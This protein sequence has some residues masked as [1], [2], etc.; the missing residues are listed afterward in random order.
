M[1]LGFKDYAALVTLL[2][3]N[4][5]VLFW[6]VRAS[7]NG[8]REGQKSMAGDVREIK[9][10]VKEIRKSDADQNVRLGRHEERID[11]LWGERT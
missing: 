8:M 9:G 10:D 6:A 2:A 7:L 4:G 11:L 1:E 3:G 5:G